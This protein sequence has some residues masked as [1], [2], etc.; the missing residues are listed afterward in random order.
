MLSSAQAS[1]S[2]SDGLDLT[3]G[4][5]FAAAWETWVAGGW[6][7]IPIFVTAAVMFGVGASVWLRLVAKGFGAVPEK[8]W[9]LW[10]AHPNHREG[11]IGELLDETADAPSTEASVA[12]FAG[13]RK[14]ELAPFAR[15]LKVMKVCVAVGPLL[16]LLGTVTGMLATFDAL[17]TGSGGDQTMAAIAKGISEALITTETGL[18]VALPGMFFHYQL[19]RKRDRYEAFLAHLETVC[20]QHIYRRLRE[21]AAA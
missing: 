3:V 10:I 16:G 21:G 19:S 8:V 18:V 4:G 2:A 7:M 11:R 12:V 14:A 9:R 5:L 13:V 6:A 1:A 17:A 20:T 15:D